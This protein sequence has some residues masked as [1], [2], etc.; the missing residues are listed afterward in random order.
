MLPPRLIELNYLWFKS[1]GCVNEDF[2]SVY[3]SLSIHCFLKTEM[4]NSADEFSPCQHERFNFLFAWEYELS[5][6]PTTANILVSE[7]TSLLSRQP[8]YLGK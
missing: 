3:N 4:E 5:T 7:H 1:Q 6:R 2:L 8:W